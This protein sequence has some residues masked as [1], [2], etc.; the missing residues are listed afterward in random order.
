MDSDMLQK[1]TQPDN[2]KVFIQENLDHKVSHEP[3]SEI[4][5]KILFMINNISASNMD[6]KAKEFT[7]VRK[8][9][10]YPWF[11]Q[12]MVIKRASIEPNFHELYLKFL[13]KVN[14]RMLNKEIVK[15]T[16]ENCKVPSQNFFVTPGCHRHHTL[17]NLP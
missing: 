15:A 17:Y 2:F 5:D 1:S 7:D 4:H 6:V 13:E 14:S 9:Q 16:C 8:E 3:A 12:Y 10:Y 11:A